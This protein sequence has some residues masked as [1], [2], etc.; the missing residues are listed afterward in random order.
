LHRLLRDLSYYKKNDKSTEFT[1]LIPQL[2]WPN[3]DTALLFLD[4]SELFYQQPTRDPWFSATTPR[5]LNSTSRANSTYSYYAADEL[6]GVLG[7]GTETRICNPKLPEGD[8]CFDGSALRFAT[9]ETLVALKRVW[10]D[11]KERSELRAFFTAINRMGDGTGA[12]L[13]TLPSVPAFLS[14]NTV[15][16]NLQT[17]KLPEDRWQT[18]MTQIFRTSLAIV[19]YMLVEHARGMWLGFDAA[20]YQGT[21]C[22]RLCHSQVS[23]SA[24]HWYPTDFRLRRKFDLRTTTHSARGHWV[25]FCSSA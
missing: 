19:Q 5:R 10:P 21:D 14:R 17:D 11:V 2:V 13:Y 3:A 22:R 24:P 12:F 23:D 8:Q 18:E 16:G 20:C 6:V 9:N 4:S 15:L 7:C 1:E 25:S